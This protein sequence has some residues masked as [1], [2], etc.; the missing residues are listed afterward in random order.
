[1]D[2]PSP[3]NIA[4][5]KPFLKWAGGK[6]QLLAEIEKALPPNFGKIKNL[7]YVEPFVGSGAVMFRLLK[8][9]PNIS[10]AVINDI[11]A[12]LHAA[13]ITIKNDPHTLIDTLAE[14][15][16]KY[17]SLKAE[18]DR[19]AFFL[20]KRSQ[21][22]AR[23]INSI[24]TTTLLIFLNRSCFNGLY[25]VNSKN[26]FNVPF[27]R[28]TNPKICDRETILA[29]SALLQRVEILNGDYTKTLEQV[30]GNAFFYFDPPYKPISKTSSF[31]AYS[32][33]VFDDAE[34][35][36]L[37]AFCDLLT[38]K[39]IKWLLS[40][41]DPKN[42]DPDDDFFDNLYK[43][44]HI[45]MDRVL[46]RRSINSNSAKRGGIKELLISNYPT[47]KTL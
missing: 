25:R 33:E 32:H 19:K 4:N 29:D 6:R 45:Y 38:E 18:A 47:S 41:S 44:K 22:N 36:R 11:N 42:I 23:E 35:V 8:T 39:K 3:Q 28:Y 34:Q 14:I 5:A 15:E 16:N 24:E 21:F 9:Y 43:G 17:Y 26:Q 2:M 27:G 37:K 46:A 12:D 31:N 7:T 20:E 13:Y 40:N 1:M 30:S 10:R